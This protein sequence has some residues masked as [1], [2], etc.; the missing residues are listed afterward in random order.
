MLYR[1]ELTFLPT[2]TKGRQKKMQ[3]LGFSIL[4]RKML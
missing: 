4:G 3:L 1:F 2:E